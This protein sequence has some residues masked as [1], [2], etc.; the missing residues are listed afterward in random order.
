MNQMRTSIQP[1]TS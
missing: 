1:V